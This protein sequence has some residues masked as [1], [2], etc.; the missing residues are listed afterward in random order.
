MKTTLMEVAYYLHSVSS[1]IKGAIACIW[2]AHYEIN[3]YNICTVMYVYSLKTPI[4]QENL[5][6]R[7]L[8]NYRMEIR[9]DYKVGDYSGIY[10]F[11]QQGCRKF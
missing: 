10:C 2:C 11:K 6:D 9:K 4:N 3:I 5:L 1:F 7:T 8:G